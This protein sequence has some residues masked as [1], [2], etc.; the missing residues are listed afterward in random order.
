MSDMDV[1]RDDI[2]AMLA[3][4]GDRPAADIPER[5][6]S[7]ELAWLL[8]QAEQRYGVPMEP[9]DSQLGRMGT[10]TGAVDVL[11]ELIGNG[12]R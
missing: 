3:S 8:H 10:V 2:V 9:D 1:G 11:R 6:D 7:M 12:K 5:I 4:L